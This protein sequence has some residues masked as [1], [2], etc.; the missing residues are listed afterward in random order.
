MEGGKPVIPPGSHLVAARAVF[1]RSDSQP[2]DKDVFLL[3]INHPA[4]N[5]NTPE[6]LK[7]SVV[8]ALKTIKHDMELREKLHTA[9]VNDIYYNQYLASAPP[10]EEEQEKEEQGAAGGKEI[11]K[12]E[13]ILPTDSETMIPGAKQDQNI[14]MTTQNIPQLKKKIDMKKHMIIVYKNENSKNK[15]TLKHLTKEY[16]EKMGIGNLNFQEQS[17]EN[18]ADATEEEIWGYLLR[19]VQEGGKKAVTYAAFIKRDVKDT[20]LDKAYDTINLD[21]E[22]RMAILISDANRSPLLKDLQNHFAVWGEDVMTYLYTIAEDA[23]KN[24]QDKVKKEEP[25]KTR[26]ITQEDIKQDVERYDANGAKETQQP[27][28]LKI[29]KQM[30][31][32]KAKLKEHKEEVKKIEK[33]KEGLYEDVSTV[34]DQLK[35]KSAR[36]SARSSIQPSRATSPT[37]SNLTGTRDKLKNV[38]AQR[39]VKKRTK[40]NNN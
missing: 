22:L 6:E 31:E 32:T 2:A 38:L 20:W 3:Q 37:N 16:M 17:Q 14:W 8:Q 36:A 25:Q 28:H 10:L 18:A 29:A 13:P 26:V 27:E 40:R 9:E 4:I 24:Q 33:V 5:Q 19:Y 30:E 23:E 11:I 7:R 39:K 15:Q 21:N 34:I 1:L 12:K 35:S